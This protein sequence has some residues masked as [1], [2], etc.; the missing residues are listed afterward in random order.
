MNSEIAL[1]CTA[2]ALVAAIAAVGYLVRGA[3]HLRTRVAG[4]EE[5]CRA[6]DAAVARLA[7]VGLPTVAEVMDETSVPRIEPAIGR[8]LEGTPFAQNIAVL[9]HRYTAGVRELQGEVARAVRRRVSEEAHQTTESS[10]RSFA[11]T[12][13]SLGASLSKVVTEAMRRHRGDE[14]FETLT[15]IDHTVQQMIRQAQSYVVVCGGLPG[16]RWP[17]QTM[18]DVVRGAMGR[19]QD[20]RRIRPRE[21]GR[22]VVGPA[23]EPAVHAVATLLDNAA[24]YSPP[25]S[26]VDVTFQEGHHGVTIIVDDAGVGMNSEQL[27][28]ARR[29]LSGQEP[30]D[31]HRFGPHPKVGF[32]TVAALSRRY[33]FQASVDGS[34][35]PFGGTRAALFI[36]EALLASAGGNGS[37]GGN[38]YATANAAPNTAPNAAPNASATDAAPAVLASAN[39]TTNTDATDA[40]PAATAAPTR[41]PDPNPSQNP[42]P[43]P[44]APTT[45]PTRPAPEP[46]LTGTGLPR[47]RRQSATADTQPL[48]PVLSTTPPRAS[49]AA[50]WQSGAHRAEGPAAPPSDPAA[51]EGTR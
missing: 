23:V 40:L 36:P 27:D 21:L 3:R 37:G 5:A 41:N 24:R 43:N 34:G 8:S 18:T 22:Q 30:V 20:Y 13:V 4:L 10:V 17:A 47:R 44:S 7:A 2:V 12:V 39:T 48:P 19:I 50:A 28:A 25:G 29:V 15:L 46:E 31:L 33:G 16:R 49:V 1:W 11:E 35:S 51:A 26:F 32:A 9:S 14:T 38:G 45:G 6:R 42:D